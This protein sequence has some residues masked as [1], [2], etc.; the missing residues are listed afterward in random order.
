MCPHMRMRAQGMDV[1]EYYA[2]LGHGARIKMFH[3]QRADLT[4]TD[5]PYELVVVAKVGGGALWGQEKS[6]QGV[7]GCC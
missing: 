3:A 7:W 2:S 1:V 5:C 4:G 6:C